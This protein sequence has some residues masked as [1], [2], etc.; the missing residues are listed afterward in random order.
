[1]LVPATTNQWG[2]HVVGKFRTLLALVDELHAV[3]EEL[4]GDIE[5]LLNLVGH[6]DDVG[7]E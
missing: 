4:A 1:M 3:L 2:G 7:R 6:C 5:D